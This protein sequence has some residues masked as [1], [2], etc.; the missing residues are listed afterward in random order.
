MR[1]FTL[2]ELIVSILVLSILTSTAVPALTQI[3]DRHQTS[4]E[5]NGFLG[6]LIKARLLA[7]ETTEIITICPILNNECVSDWEQPISIFADRDNNHLINNK[8]RLYFQFDQPSSGTWLT[9]NN[10]ADG[11][12]FYPN[13]HA[14]GSASTLVYCP[15]SDNNRLAKQLIIN[16]QGRIRT[17]EYLSANGAP[18]ASLGNLLCT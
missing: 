8:D 11:I 4:S 14:Y 5:I 9:R 7:I 1:G 17:S 13:G 6:Y 10:I 12:Q 15:D 18:Y 16:F 2:I 3:Y